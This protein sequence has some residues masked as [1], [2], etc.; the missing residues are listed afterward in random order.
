MQ[1][2]FYIFLEEGGELRVKDI[3]SSLRV[4]RACGAKG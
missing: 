3:K 4:V 2:K 1:E